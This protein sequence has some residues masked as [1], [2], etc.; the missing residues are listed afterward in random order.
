MKNKKRS[1]GRRLI[2]FLARFALSA[3]LL[4]FVCLFLYQLALEYTV[5]EGDDPTAPLVVLGAQI[6]PDG[7]PNVQLEWR[8]EKALAAYQKQQRLVVVTGGQGKNEP[9]P[10]AHAMRDWLLARG[11]APEHILVD[12]QSVT[13]RQNI[14]NAMKLLPADK[15]TVVLV[16]SSYHVPRAVRLARDMGVEAY[17]MGSPIKQEFWLKNHARETLAWGKYFLAKVIPYF[18]N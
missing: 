4:V 6:L 3:F 13:T 5:K 11:V 8:L 7:Q 2:G 18:A 9:R 10:E 1:W 12:D 17:G 15:K 14:Q 16:S